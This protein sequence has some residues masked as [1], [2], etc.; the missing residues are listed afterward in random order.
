MQS[1]GYERP[2]LPN[3]YVEPD[4]DTEEKLADI[5]QQL[6]GIQKIGRDD[7]VFRMGAHSLIALQVVNRLRDTFD[8]DLQLGTAF[9]APT[10]AELAEKIDAARKAAQKALPPIQAIARQ[11]QAP[12]PVSCAQQNL[13]ELQELSN[14]P[15]KVGLLGLRRRQSPPA[16]LGSV[17]FNVCMT[18][19]FTGKLDVVVL[20]RS[21]SAI[22]QRHETLR[23]HFVSVDGQLTAVVSAARPVPLPV[24]DAP[25]VEVEKLEN[26]LWELVARQQQQSFRQ[27][28]P[29][30]WRVQLVRIGEDEHRLI[31]CAHRS[32]CDETSLEILAQELVVFYR[33]NHAGEA[34]DVAQPSV[35]YVDY[36]AWQ[37]HWLKDAVLQAHLEYWKGRLL[38]CQPVLMLPAGWKRAPA[39]HL[40]TAAF[41]L[42]P[43][44]SGAIH[45]LS[46]DQ[47]T[48]LFVTLLSAFNLLLFQCTGQQDIL[49]GAPSA[50]RNRSELEGLIGLFDNILALRSAL[51]DDQ[52]F[53]QLIGQV[54]QT[55]LEA[56]VHQDMPFE[57]VLKTLLPERNP[58]VP[59]LQVM[60]SLENEPARQMA[61]PDLLLEIPRV[62]GREANCDLILA[63]KDT[64]EGL[65]GVFEYNLD[66]LKATTIERLIADF[67]KLLQAVVIDPGQHLVNFFK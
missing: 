67:K 33:A 65:C 46:Q 48:S 51:S 49:I 60:F 19:R 31:W 43:E 5:W 44:L 21:L 52:T 35:Q 17:L 45:T 14:P 28:E 24:V 55:V 8:I 61:L 36:A 59:L 16:I 64:S 1:Q 12:L 63:M 22:V 15:E 30:L 56:Q 10:I 7:N 66:L 39:T 4:G 41:K 27:D 32:V 53:L 6:L 62:S 3:D 2:N 26:Y 20:E 18:L 25:A 13:W 29:L 38:S 40:A 47:R 58:K 11:E 42:P 34:V 57:M 37:R 23:T 54:H 9:E 50:N